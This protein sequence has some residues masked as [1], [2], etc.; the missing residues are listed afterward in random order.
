M[1]YRLLLFPCCLLL[2]HGMFSQQV[3]EQKTYTIY[4]NCPDSMVKAEVYYLNPGL[5][6]AKD[7]FYAWYYNNMIHSTEGGF[8]GKLLHGA[9]T[10]SYPNETMKEQGEFKNGLK[11]GTWKKWYSSGV[12][13]EIAYWDDGEKD[14]AYVLYGTSGKKIL[15]ASY[16]NGKLHGTVTSYE[17]GEVKMKREYKNGEEVKEKEKEKEKDR[18]S[19]GKIF[20]LGRRS[21]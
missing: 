11:K 19:L 5:K 17:D 16:R 21:N 15:E 20:G 18:F 14:G 10:C 7:H 4:L 13:A 3:N 12:I 6:P 8:N 1:I 9:Y 2:S